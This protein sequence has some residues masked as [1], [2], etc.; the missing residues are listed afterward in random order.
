MVLFPMRMTSLE[1][2]DFLFLAI[3]FVLSA[4][5]VSSNF[6]QGPQP[7]ISEFK[8]IV[9]TNVKHHLPAMY[10]FIDNKMP[11]VSY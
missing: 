5:R 9:T 3:L 4:S 10:G 7:N 11:E 1:V 6:H 2:S 8:I